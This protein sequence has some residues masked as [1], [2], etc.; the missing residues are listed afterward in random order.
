MP[1]ERRTPAGGTLKRATR[2]SDCSHLP[3]RKTRTNHQNG[4]RPELVAKPLKIAELNAKLYGKAKQ[5]CRA[6]GQHTDDSPT[7]NPP[8]KPDAGN[9]HVRFEEGDG[10]GKGRAIS[11]LPLNIF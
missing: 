7:M 1:V 2:R 3:S 5:V 8:G 6:V 11:T 9:L 4:H 10:D